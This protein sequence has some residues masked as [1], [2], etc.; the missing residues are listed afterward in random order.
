[1]CSA[2]PTDA[3]ADPSHSR[4]ALRRVRLHLQRVPQVA[5]PP[6]PRVQD[7]PHWCAFLPCDRKL[8]NARPPSD[9]IAPQSS[10]SSGSRPSTASSSR[11]RSAHPT[12]PPRASSPPAP[13]SSP[14]P[15]SRPPPLSLPLLLLS[16]RTLQQGTPQATASRSSR[17]SHRPPHKPQRGSSRLRM[18]LRARG[19]CT[20]PR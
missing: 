9:T 4:E 17:K 2:S 13:S 1:M 14:P 18:H 3:C 15:S 16:M 10:R 6:L 11:A 7:L 19:M 20:S 5:R 12:S 8:G